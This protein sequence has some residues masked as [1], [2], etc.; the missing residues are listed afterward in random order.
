MNCLKK[1]VRVPTG[2]FSAFAVFVVSLLGLQTP[3]YAAK[4]STRIPGYPTMVF[5]GDM[6]HI[7]DDY[8]YVDRTLNIANQMDIFQLYK[9]VNSGDSGVTMEELAYYNESDM[10]IVGRQI[11]AMTARA[12][13][14]VVS[15]INSQE[16]FTFGISIWQ[17]LDLNKELPNMALLSN[18]PQHALESWE[19][20]TR[21]DDFATARDAVLP[22]FADARV[23]QNCTSA[24]IY[25]N[26][27]S[28]VETLG[29]SYDSIMNSAHTWSS[30]RLGAAR[31]FKQEPRIE[32][33]NLK[34]AS[35]LRASG[36][37]TIDVIVYDGEDV[38]EV[39]SECVA[40]LFEATSDLRDWDGAAK[41]SPNAE[42]V[43]GGRASTVKVKVIPG[44]GSA[45]KA[46]LRLKEK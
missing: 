8:G 25:A 30:Y 31:L 26:F 20:W 36:T 14:T 5:R 12:Q 1:N 9:Y 35:G 38:S 15:V 40:G 24:Q 45:P 13:S 19:L 22:L 32:M 37:M 23:L 18:N 39:S 27:L 43:T 3:L 44:D 4:Y 2:I 11:W 33:S 41:L 46:F 34:M 16:F 29:Q 17:A 6:I 10:G 42:P 21:P 28:W 7:V